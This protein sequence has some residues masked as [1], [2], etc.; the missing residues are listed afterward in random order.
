MFET[1]NINRTKERGCGGG[2]VF[3]TFSFDVYRQL[4]IYGFMVNNNKDCKQGRAKWLIFENN[5][6]YLYI[7]L[8]SLFVC[9][10]VRS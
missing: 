10:F 2:S 8:K 4:M 6:L 7:K 3:F 1:T 5:S 9:L